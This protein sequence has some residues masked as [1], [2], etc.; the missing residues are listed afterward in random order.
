MSLFKSAFTVSGLT[1]ISRIL[2]YIRDIL[3]ARYIGTGVIA[4][5]F[6]VAFRLPNFFRQLCA[7]GAF[8]NAFVPIFAGKLSVDGEEKAKNF[9]QNIF[10]IM[11]IF[12][13]SIC[14]LMIILMPYVMRLLAPG[15]V[16][17]ILQFEYVVTFGRILFSYLFF[18]SLVALFGGILNSIGK[19]AAF[20][21][22]P[23]LLNITLIS[24]LLFFNGDIYGT[25]FNLSIAVIVAGSLQLCWLL[26]FAYKNN[27]LLKIKKP[28]ITPD[29][30]LLFKRMVPGVIGG[31]V[32]QINLWVNTLLATLIPSAVSYLYFADRIVQ[33]PLALIGTAMGTALLPNLSKSI[34][35]QDFEG[36][37]KTQNKALELVLIFT[38]PA[39]VGLII[40]GVDLVSL[41]FERGE[42][43]ALSSHLTAKALICY[44]F[45]LPAFVMIKIFAPSFFATG[46]TKTPVKIAIICLVVNVVVS[47]SL[48]NSLG[49]LALAIATSASSWLNFLLLLIILINNK[50]FKPINN[51]LIKI[52]TILV[53]TFIMAFALYLVKDY[54]YQY[55]QADGFVRVV[56]VGSAIISSVLIYFSCLFTFKKLV[57]DKLS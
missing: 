21:A 51:L 27:F 22:S 32:M 34:R 10:A 40:L 3:I 52:L 4:D 19:F 29:T 18:I 55:F 48:M 26:F 37:N 1:L 25:A 31:G 46:D 2:G 50:Q 24:C 53:C 38:L 14:L 44:A 15:F 36:A 45:G 47:L 7:E 6:F 49:H 8:N 12:L 11:L 16:D 57:L 43:T 5:A 9:A 30:K 13:V 23:I 35:K 28:K 42:F 17:D 33:F 41:M 54:F 56:V 20:A 39:T